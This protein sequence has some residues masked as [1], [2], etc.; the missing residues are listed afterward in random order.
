M[1]RRNI[2]KSRTL[3]EPK[4]LS[5]NMILQTIWPSIPVAAGPK[6]LVAGAWRDIQSTSILID[7][8]WRTV[9]GISVIKDGVWRTQ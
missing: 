9:V 4:K 2:T 7:G 5:A 6:V 1:L 8:T 3:F